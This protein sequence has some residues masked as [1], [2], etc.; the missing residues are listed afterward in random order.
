MFLKS[1]FPGK[2]IQGE[3]VLNQLPHWVQWFGKKGLILASRSAK[4]KILGPCA[5]ALKADAIIIDSF[6]GE[7]CE[8]E[9]N[10]LAGV[11]DRGQADVLIGMG[12]GKAIDT[13]KIAADRAQIPVIIVHYCLDGCTLQ[14][15]RRPLY[16]SRRIR[17]RLLPENQ[18]AGGA[19]GHNRHR[20]CSGALSGFRNGRRAGHLV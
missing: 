5:D 13:A 11:I 3:G 17:F 2:Y 1:V 20:R 16:G 12:G 14:R 10:R 19:G 9:L 15:L 4:E 7:C 18:P 6:H 8:K